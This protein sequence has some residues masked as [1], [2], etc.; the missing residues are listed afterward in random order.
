MNAM[1]KPPG[2][3]EDGSIVIH[4]CGVD[5]SLITIIEAGM[6]TES[7]GDV[8]EI[9]KIYPGWLYGVYVGREIGM[10]LNVGQLSQIRR[11]LEEIQ[12][13][14]DPSKDF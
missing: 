3:R 6:C 14:I 5:E 12:F 2:G 7:D 8:S 1:A 10:A 9:R 13:I 11:K 4:I